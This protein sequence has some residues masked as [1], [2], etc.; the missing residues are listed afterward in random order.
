MH[1]DV[2]GAELVLDGAEGRDQDILR[3]S[4]NEIKGDLGRVLRIREAINGH[5]ELAEELRLR[6]H[7]L[8]D[9][10]TAEI[11]PRKT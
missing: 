4:K 6:V 8:S 7:L 9:N 10:L 3:R 2:H 11:Q 5:V 1:L